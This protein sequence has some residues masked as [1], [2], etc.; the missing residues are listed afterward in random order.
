VYILMLADV[1]SEQGTF[2]SAAAPLDCNHAWTLIINPLHLYVLLALDI[3][4]PHNSM[5][6]II[7]QFRSPFSSQ[8][9][10]RVKVVILNR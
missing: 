8:I 1:L 5:H 6:G 7:T 3:Q 2:E 9:I 10:G 4:K